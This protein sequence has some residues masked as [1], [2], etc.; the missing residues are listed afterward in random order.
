[1]VAGEAGGGVGERLLDGGAVVEVG[2][3]ERVVLED[4]GDVVGAV[5]EAHHLVVHGGGAAADA[6]LFGVVQ[7]L[8][9]AGRFALVVSVDRH[10]SS[11]PPRGGYLPKV[12]VSWW[13]TWWCLR[14]T[15]PGV[16]E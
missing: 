6:V 13:L 12:F 2:D 9:L 1:V 4:G 8:A 3:F 11:Y 15:T 16:A 10:V 14:F 5:L 7:A